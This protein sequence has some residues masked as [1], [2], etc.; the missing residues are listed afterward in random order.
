MAT[1]EAADEL[2]DVRDAAT[3]VGRSAETV[4]RWIWSGR[5]PARRAGRKLLVT[6]RDLDAFQASR[7]ATMT[8]DEWYQRYIV[9]RIRERPRWRGSS[10]DLVIEDR[11][12]RGDELLRRARR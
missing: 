9:N 4:R 5:L 6:R 8:L 3:L 10:A 7:A 2:I 1:S 11:N 12:S